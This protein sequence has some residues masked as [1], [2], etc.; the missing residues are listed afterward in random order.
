MPVDIGVT[1]EG[2]SAQDSP[3]APAP[4]ARVPFVDRSAPMF[5]LFLLFAA[6]VLLA[7][8]LSVHSREPQELVNGP[9]SHRAYVVLSHW[10][11]EGYFH[12]F[13]LINREVD[14]TGIYRNST[15][16]Y[17][18]S[19]FIVEKLY[20]AATGHFSYR[21]VA[22]HNQIVSMIISALGGL[23]SY[24]LARR[25]GLEPRLAFAAGASVVALLFTFPDN[26]DLY[27]EM[28]AQAYWV[29]F[30]LLYFVIEERSIDHSMRPRHL[31]LAQAASVFLMTVMESIVTL[32][33][34]VSMAVTI[35]ILRRERPWKRFLLIVVLPCV[36]SLALYQLQLKAGQMRFPNAPTSGSKVLFRTGLDGESLYYGDHLGII[37]RRDVARGNW[38]ANRDFLFRWKWVFLL[39]VTSV[40]ATIV[41]YIRGR[42]PLLLLEILVP[43]IGGW[44]IYA[45]IFSQSVVIHPYLYDVLLYTPLCLALFGLA[46]ALLESMT[47]RTGAILLLFVFT[48][49][50]YS[51]FQMRLYSLRRPMPTAQAGT[52]PAGR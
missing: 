10:L 52:G 51:F 3:V 21:V 45:A 32:G 40:L 5:S 2:V 7:A 37:T 50:W 28:S 16:G 1:E 36:A 18:L 12:Y 22:L 17:M 23:L 29:L 49:I 35:A 4:A 25:L 6:G 14:K 19:G 47:R 43:L 30:A 26:L 41:A 8:M 27:W 38:Q 31:L 13:G 24:R 9:G 39:G 48:A 42:V 15:G 46:P 11:N 33:F 44:L 34:I 20:S